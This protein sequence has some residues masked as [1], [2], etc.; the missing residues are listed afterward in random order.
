MIEN[1]KKYRAH[2]SHGVDVS[3]LITVSYAAVCV[4]MLVPYARYASWTVPLF[5]LLW[6]KESDFVLFMEAQLLPVAAAHALLSAVIDWPLTLLISFM[7]RSVSFGLTLLGGLTD[8]IA[9]II[10]AVITVVPI[11]VLI[12]V[13][14]RARHYIQA[15]IIWAGTVAEKILSAERFR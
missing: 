5:L 9:A 10:S 6:E 11:V 12:L 13:A 4:L 1:I 2:T 8:Y 14:S 3:L 15:R 7:N